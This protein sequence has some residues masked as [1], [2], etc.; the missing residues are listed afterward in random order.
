MTKNEALQKIEEL[1]KFVE[2]C[3]QEPQ[4]KHGDEVECEYGCKRIVIDMGKIR[5]IYRDCKFLLLDRDGCAANAFTKVVSEM[6][7]KYTKIRNV[8]ED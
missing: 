1:K 5:H 2:K 6:C 3:D 8:F 4:L 7:M